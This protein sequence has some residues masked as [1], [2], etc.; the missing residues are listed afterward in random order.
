[1]LST[2]LRNLS[3]QIQYDIENGE[4]GVAKFI[5]QGID[6]T[7]NF[8]AQYYMLKNAFGPKG[9]GS[10][11]SM[12]TQSAT[13]KYFDN[14]QKGYDMDTSLLNAIATGIASYATEKIGMDNFVASINGTVNQSIYTQALNSIAKGDSNLQFLARAIASQGIAEGLE[15]VVEGNVDYILDSI[16]A[17]MANGEPIEYNAGDIFYSMLVGAFSGGLTG[18][19]GGYEGIVVNTRTQYNNLRNDVNKLIEIRDNGLANGEDVT[20]VERAIVVGEQALNNFEDKSKTMGVT[21]ANELVEENPSYEAEK[22]I[23]T[24]AL[25][26]DVDEMVATSAETD[27]LIQNV[28]NTSQD[29]LDMNE[30]NMPVDEFVSLSDEQRTHLMENAQKINQVFPNVNLSY[31]TSIGDNALVI[32]MDGNKPTIIVNPNGDT[33]AVVSTVHEVVHTL[34]NTDAYQELFNTVFPNAESFQNKFNEL[35]EDRYKGDD[36][37]TVRKEALTVA[38]TEDLMGDEGAQ[39]FIDHLSKYN[40]STAYRLLYNFE[41][42]TGLFRDNSTLGR[43]TRLLTNALSNQ[44]A[45]YLSDD[46]AFSKRHDYDSRRQMYDFIAEYKANGE[47]AFLHGNTRMSPL[48]RIGKYQWMP[49]G[50]PNSPILIQRRALE[51]VLSG[52]KSIGHNEHGKI[53]ENILKN[54]DYLMDNPLAVFESKTIDGAYMVILDAKD[55]NGYPIIASLSP[56]QNAKW[57]MNYYD[58]NFDR[59]FGYP[60]LVTGIYGKDN[61]EFAT[62]ENGNKYLTKKGRGHFDKFFYGLSDPIFPKGQTKSDV[63][64]SVGRLLL[65]TSPDTSLNSNITDYL[66]KSRQL[67]IIQESNPM[68]DDIHT[69]IRSIDDILTFE[70]AI[71]DLDDVI[72]TPDWTVKDAQ[73][74]LEDG[75]VMVF[76]S[77]PIEA[78]TF[79]TPSMQQAKDYAGKKGKVYGTDVDLNDVAWIDSIEGQYA[80]TFDEKNRL[81]FAKNN[82]VLDANN[83]QHILSA[84]EEFESDEVKKRL[85]YGDEDNDNWKEIS[86]NIKK[87]SDYVFYH[88]LHNEMVELK[89]VWDEAQAITNEKIR[90]I[91]GLNVI[92]LDI[93]AKH[94]GLGNIIINPGAKSV[95]SAETKVMKKRIDEPD[96]DASTLRDQNRWSVQVES[97]EDIPEVIN[98]IRK[99]I[100]N[101]DLEIKNGNDFYEIDKDGN[102]VEVK[103]RELNNFGYVGFHITWSENGIN[104]EIQV[105]PD[106][107]RKLASDK[108]Y[109]K[110]RRLDYK[111]MSKEKK[112]EYQEDRYYSKELWKASVEGNLPSVISKIIE[113]ETGRSSSGLINQGRSTSTQSLDDVSNLPTI[114][115]R[116]DNNNVGES[117]SLT[118]DNPLGSDNISIPPSSNDIITQDNQNGENIVR[119]TDTDRSNYKN[120]STDR[121][122]ITLDEA[123][124]TDISKMDATQLSDVAERIRQYVIAEDVE[125]I[126]NAKKYTLDAINENTRKALGLLDKIAEAVPKTINDKSVE[127]QRY[128]EQLLDEMA[129]RTFNNIPK[130]KKAWIVVGPSASGK[131]SFIDN[132]L[133]ANGGVVDSDEFKY[134]T[135]EFKQYGGIM[136][137]AL[138]AESDILSQMLKQRG[139]GEGYNM[140]FPLVGKNTQKI[141]DLVH[142]LQKHGYNVSISGT[143]LPIEKA[144]YRALNRFIEDD[145]YLRFDYMQRIDDKPTNTFNVVKEMEGVENG[146]LWS[147]DVE[148]GQP[149]QRIDTELRGKVSEGIQQSKETPSELVGTRNNRGDGLRSNAINDSESTDSFSNDNGT[150]QYSRRS[151]TRRVE[152][153]V[154]DSYGETRQQRFPENLD[155]S[156]VLNNEQKENL[157]QRV[158]NNEFTYQS[159]VNKAEVQKAREYMQRDGV[160]KYFKDYMGNNSPSAKTVVAGEVLLTELAKNK[161][162]RWEQ[163][164]TKLAD[165]ATIAGQFLQAY[166]IMQRLTPDGQLVA[167][168]RNM[169]RMQQSLDNRFGNK[170]PKLEL[171]ENLKEDLLNATTAEEAE[172]ARD[173]IYKDLMNQTPKTVSDVLNSWRYLAMLANPRTHIRNI[174]GNGVFVP[175]IE[176]K[177]AIGT[178]LEST[179]GKSLGMQYRT[180][181]LLNPF[182]NADKALIDLGKNKY[183]EHKGAIEKNQKYERKQFSNKNIFGRGLNKIS[184]FNSWALDKEDFMFSKDRFARSYAQFLKSNGV[185]TQSLTEEMD[186]R[187]TEY[188]MLEAE[189]ATYRD[190]NSVAEW[191]NELE[192]SDK[193]GL[194]RASAVKKAILPFTKTPMNIILRGARYS[195]AGLLYTITYDSKQLADGMINANQYLDNM[196]SG[197]TGTSIALLGALL[198]SMG[199][200]RTKDDDEDRKKYFDSENG[201]QDY[202]IDLSPFGINGTYTIDWASPVVMPFAMGAELFNSL[203]DMGSMMDVINSIGSISAKMFDPMIET[204]MLS[205]LQDALKSYSTNGGEWLAEVVLTVATSYISQLFPTLGGQIAR[206]ID[207]TRRTTYPNSGPVDKALKQIYNKIPWMS[208]LNRPYINRQG[209]EEKSEDLGMGM[210]G[211]GI[212]NMLSPG[213]YSSKDIDEYDEELYRLYETTGDLDA[214]PS[215]TSKSTTYDKEDY[216]FT[217]EQYTEWHKTRWQTETEYVNQFIDSK[218]YQNLTDEERVETIKD[219]RSYAQK[220]AKQEFLKSQGIDYDDKQLSGAEGAIDNGIELYAYFDYLNNAGSKQAEKVAYLEKSGLSKKQK[221]Y[222][223]SLDD[224]KKSYEDV[225]EKVFGGTNNSSSKNKSSSSGSKKSSK[226]KT[227]TSSSRRPSGGGKSSGTSPSYKLGSLSTNRPNT[228]VFNTNVANAYLNAYSNNLGRSTRQGNGVGTR[229]VCPRCKNT[230]VPVNGRCPICGTGLQ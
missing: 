24:E 119:K 158:A 213:Y 228:D 201:E 219:I 224:Y 186:K 146:G 173:A 79:V 78:G 208:K 66:R 20:N 62:D 76:S 97:I 31:S 140:I 58:V 179:V 26:P 50:M 84:K 49:E 135:K 51:G 207:D 82:K 65:S 114:Q 109:D 104:S 55:N 144:Q 61:F 197:L 188:A 193:K 8:L 110:W 107:D 77:K 229:V 112:I 38:L 69:G 154:V 67:E 190:A 85:K 184:D 35:S 21:Y 111:K 170:A 75:H 95:N 68:L 100:P 211:R 121:T 149:Y 6:S 166:S 19:F 175:A 209:Q 206:T 181:S 203:K 156:T 81:E 183:E 130:D 150:I 199:I 185:D 90:D 60:G 132:Y 25:R 204:S 153:E 200:F 4:D 178:A 161:D 34:E 191:L 43:I 220:V 129:E 36:F 11:V 160:D 115:P 137:D 230:V 126:R 83:P 182:S 120:W 189:K 47:K 148:K 22:E 41:N 106:F 14:I 155:K 187:A 57:K 101:T 134:A 225:Y 9:T 30:V 28:M 169:N 113:S 63:I 44:E 18:A 42:A 103:G 176:L 152:G 86:D 151:N 89:K 180:K 27:A 195:P 172:K 122:P 96:F 133:N 32:K 128:R 212:L 48:S 117:A 99:N 136:S 217:P 23:L 10:L 5:G 210:F 214:F 163:V 124:R 13:Q 215:N 108:F 102:L 1:M 37:S 143:V 29:F 73:K 59:G 56:R 17:K 221:D 226:T 194:R 198:A 39:A 205:S 216:K 196:A 145:R 177:N 116:S 139:L 16:T 123:L 118:I 71:E 141:V 87:D 45:V 138:H 53:N 93:H 98:S 147:A 222:L 74:A 12:S 72:S 2:Q 92:P 171:K 91:L 33:S 164:A 127:R 168:T 54:L 162:P 174:L 94:K 70:E 167:L 202:A 223:W 40:T 165:D 88:N 105:T 192:Y 64:K 7:L 142:D 52:K 15:E 3:T 157:R 46:V 80:P 218:A 227:K 131:S 125:R 159:L